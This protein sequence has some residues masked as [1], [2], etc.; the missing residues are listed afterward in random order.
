M[1]FEEYQEVREAISEAQSE[2]LDQ[3]EQAREA[4]YFVNK[5]DGQWEPEVISKLKGK[6]RYT[7]DRTN[8]IVNQ[9]VADITNSDFTIRARPAGGD[10]SKDTSKIYDGVIRS[11]RNHSKFQSTLNHAARIVVESG[12]DGWEI[13][14]DYLDN[15][16]FDQDLIIKPVHNWID[17][18]FF[19]N[20]YA[21]DGSD[22]DAA[23]VLDYLSMAEY[24]KEYPE[25]SKKSIDNGSWSGAY[26]RHGEQV[27]I[28]RLYYKKYKKSKLF[29]MSNGAIYED[30]EDFQTVLDELEEF[31]VTIEDER[32]I[33]KSTVYIRTLDGGGWLDEE[34]ETIFDT[35]PLVPV[36]GNYKVSEGKI[37]YRGAVEKLMDQQRVLN[38]AFSRNV[39]EVALSP[40]QKWLMT[41]EQAKGHSESLR[42]MNTNMNPVQFYNHVEGQPAPFYA[43]GAQP[44]PAVQSLIELSESSLAASAGVFAANM[45]DNPGLQS[46]IAIE[47]QISQGNNS[48]G[49]YFEA[50]KVAVIRT[51][52]ILVSAIPKVY[53]STR[54]IRLIGEDGSI[55]TKVINQTIIDEQ[56]GQPVTLND[57]SIGKYDIVCDIGPRYAN[58]QKESAEQFARI[59]QTDPAVMELARDIFFK[60][61]NEPGFDDVAERA[62]VVALN[63]G[64]IPLEQMTE[65]ERAAYEQEQA[66]AAQEP[67]PV[68]PAAMA[69]AE[70]EMM[71]AQAEMLNAQNKQ[72]EL[73]INAG[74]LQVEAQKV[75]LERQGKVEKMESETALNIAKIDQEQQKIDLQAQEKQSRIML[76][77]QKQIIDT[78]KTQAEILNLL[79]Q[80]T[81]ADAI[82]NP[83]TIEAYNNVSEDINDASK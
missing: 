19:L 57:L 78:Q 81:G 36:Y 11:I 69:M 8:P 45:G 44:N 46:G 55:E 37:L 42:T 7:N 22:A 26:Y 15:E 72:Q 39:E 71:K 17:R 13:C 74:K 41:K 31:G 9:I 80:A 2:D 76:D 14:H 79:K 56:T 33:E 47:K 38:Y 30:D 29:K 48:S 82:L 75:S 52:E 34:E 12:L 1:N 83:N 62:R 65:D 53:D 40:R 10:A 63:N 18:V 60:N 28:G 59:A 6:P 27:T 4:D 32:E 66:Q 20:G 51:G 49:P 5:R 16:S 50:L 73:Q 68:D 67:P 23:V 54:Q 24:E 3:R 61:I 70:A 58:R 77:M 35:I 64:I 21:R 25:G 43:G